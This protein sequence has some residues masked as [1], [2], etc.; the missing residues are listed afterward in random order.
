VTQSP[1]RLTL[2]EHRQVLEWLDALESKELDFA[3]VQNVHIWAL[4]GVAALV[5]SS[6]RGQ[7]PIHLQCSSDDGPGRFAH[8]VGFERLIGASASITPVETQRTVRLRRVDRLEEIER[9]AAE[10]SRLLLQTT[11]SEDTRQTLYYILVEFLRNAVQHSRDLAGAIVG[12]QLMDRSSEYE[13]RPVIQVAVGDAG[14]GIMA[15]LRQTYPNI[16]DAHQALVSA[17]QPWVSSTFYPGDRGT[18]TN[19]GLGLYFISEMAKKTA[20]RFLLASRGGALLLEGDRHYEGHHHIAAEPYGF[21]GTLVGFELPLGGIEDYQALIAVIQDEAMARIPSRSRVQW[22]TFGP[23][24]VGSLSIVVRVGAEDTAHAERLV[25]EHLSP[26]V[27]RGEPIELDFA[28]LA[29]CTQSYVH[30]LLFSVLRAAYAHKTPIHIINASP[31]VISSLE[32]LER[33]ALPA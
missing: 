1:S 7:R 23:A 17:Q 30:S 31:A 8:A 11:E 9:A 4:V 21:A 22:L 10:I 6:E 24:P 16:R 29:V 12:A 25:R 33:Y 20:G 32:F 2:T 28:R 5:S 13:D 19:A 26:R 14:T 3:R 27:S 18:S 15:S